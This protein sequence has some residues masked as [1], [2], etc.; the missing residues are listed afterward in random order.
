MA[1]VHR[2]RSKRRVRPLRRVTRSSKKAGPGRQSGTRLLPFYPDTE[3]YRLVGLGRTARTRSATGRGLGGK[4]HVL[5]DERRDLVQVRNTA[6]DRCLAVQL[7][8]A[9]L[10]QPVQLG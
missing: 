6:S 8:A 1:C 7:A 4:P 9:F 10:M 2:W 3:R 5:V